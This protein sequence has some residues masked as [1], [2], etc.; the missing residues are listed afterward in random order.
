MRPRSRSSS[1]K[2]PVNSPYALSAYCVLFASVFITI[3]FFL[4]GLFTCYTHEGDINGR[5]I[6]A[7]SFALLVSSLAFFIRIKRRQV[8][9]YREDAYTLYIGTIIALPAAQWCVHQYVFAETFS[10][11][12]PYR[13]V[14]LMCLLVWLCVLVF[15]LLTDLPG[16]E[17]HPN[18]KHWTCRLRRLLFGPSSPNY[19]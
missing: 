6:I 13:Y 5:W 7:I 15:N 18:R 17:R 10:R 9:L 4:Y 3:Q 16:Y 14:E 19:N 8:E 12:G 1:S 11:L 2:K